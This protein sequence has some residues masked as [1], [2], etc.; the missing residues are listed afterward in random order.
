VNRAKLIK[1]I[2]KGTRLLVDDVR[3]TT[4]KGELTGKGR[5][6]C[7]GGSFRFM[8]TLD[9]GQE[10]PE[11]P[12]GIYGRKDCWPLSGT[13]E[14]HLPFKSVMGPLP[15]R[16]FQDRTVQLR[17]GCD[18]L[19]LEATGT[20][21]LTSQEIGRLVN[22]LE[23]L[24]EETIEP[25]P[26]GQPAA[27]DCHFK[28][29]LNGFELIDCDVDGVHPV[30]D[31]FLLRMIK[32]RRTVLSGSLGESFEYLLWEKKE[33]LEFHLQSKNGYQSLGEAEDLKHLNA[34]LNTLGFVFG[35]HPWH[36]Q[37]EFRRD[38][39]LVLDRVRP[40][41]VPAN[42]RFTPF[43]DRQFYSARG[44][45]HEWSTRKPIAL[46]YAYFLPH[47]AKSR[48]M[49]NFLFHFREGAK[50]KVHVRISATVLCPILE[51]LVRSL[52][53]E[54][55]LRGA[56]DENFEK[57]RTQAVTA[58]KAAQTGCT[59]EELKPIFDRFIGRS[60]KMEEWDTSEYF[61][62]LVAHFGLVWEPRWEQIFT[63]WK[64]HRNLVLHRGKTNPDDDYRDDLIVCSR[65]AGAI[66]V[67]VLKRFG[68]SGQ[69][70]WSAYN[71]DYGNI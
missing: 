27:C 19:D 4:N 23:D 48:E 10:P 61:R 43:S 8:V 35:R 13:I 42:I 44:Q 38:A 71:D 11:N 15:K 3:I 36:F 18:H 1:H 67:L 53:S 54:F 21:K 20:D 66:N 55:K 62:A 25:P 49:S 52:A 29:F 37:L 32:P 56:R 70:R 65:I 60:E 28:G 26:A 68:F 41:T 9:P 30:E 22:S 40:D 33:G 50:G 46:A 31:K 6:H 34:F 2:Q 58:L 69:V 14:D 57:V 17:F 64:K 5:L 16:T 24:E 45:K 47:S 7:R 59:D 12:P 39:K 63:I 51:N